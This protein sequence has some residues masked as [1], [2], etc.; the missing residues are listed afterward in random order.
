[1]SK[2]VEGCLWQDREIRF[3]IDDKL[4][5]ER[6]GEKT[7]GKFQILD[8][9]LVEFF[10]FLEYFKQRYKPYSTLSRILRVTMEYEVS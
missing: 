5:K 3:D 4:I 10:L 2:V 7:L 6:S 8:E 9:S 1:M